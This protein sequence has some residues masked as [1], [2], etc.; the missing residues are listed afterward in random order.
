MFTI[1]ELSLFSSGLELQH[2]EMFDLRVI[3]WY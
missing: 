3:I 1:H 2:E